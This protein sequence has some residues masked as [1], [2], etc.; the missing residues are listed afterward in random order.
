LVPAL[1]AVALFAGWFIGTSPTRRENNQRFVLATMAGVF[2]ANLATSALNALFPRPRPF[3]V[4]D[5][6]LLF[7]QPTDPS[8]PSNPAVVGFAL[9]LGVWFLNRR[10][11]A[12]AF[13]L[14]AIFAVSRIYV[15]VAYPSDV[16]AG[17][18]V[19]FLGTLLGP[20]VVRWCEPIPTRFLRWC[21]RWYLA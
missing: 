5:V 15:G 6:N 10:L 4:H 7:Y 18:I 20:F 3:H 17:A 19:G 12:L 8:F 1:L 14:A 21:R 13:L 9:A 11:G 2:L 16:L